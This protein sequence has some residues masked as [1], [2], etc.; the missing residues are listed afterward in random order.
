MKLEKRLLVAKQRCTR[1][2]EKK[3]FEQ[4]VLKRGKKVDVPMDS[5]ADIGVVLSVV[6]SMV[7]VGKC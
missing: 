6:E 1:I 3:N 5:L 2:K 4:V 7:E